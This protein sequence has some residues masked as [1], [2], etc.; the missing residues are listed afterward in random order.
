MA[1]GAVLK[2]PML[3][4]ELI[5]GWPDMATDVSGDICTELRAHGK[6]LAVPANGLGTLPA[7]VL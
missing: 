2:Q 1:P 7:H 3:L 6:L 5:P 4:M